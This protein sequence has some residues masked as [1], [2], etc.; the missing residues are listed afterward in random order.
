MSTTALGNTDSKA[1]SWDTVSTNMSKKCFK[2]QNGKLCTI[3]AVS[4]WFIFPY[5]KSIQMSVWLWVMQYLW[6]LS[7]KVVCMCMCVCLILSICPNLFI[8]ILFINTI[9]GQIGDRKLQWL[10]LPFTQTIKIKCRDS[11]E[12]LYWPPPLWRQMEE[13]SLVAFV[14]LILLNCAMWL[15]DLFIQWV[16]YTGIQGAIKISFGAKINGNNKKQDERQSFYATAEVIMSNI[17]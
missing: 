2:P 3:T 13:L 17:Y 4:L 10:S 1:G 7:G 14:Q 5:T 16:L 12:H 15:S 8:P 11:A 6:S 9:R